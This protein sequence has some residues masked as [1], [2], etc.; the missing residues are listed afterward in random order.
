MSAELQARRLEYGRALA[1]FLE[2]PEREEARL[3]AYDFGRRALANGVGLLELAELHH[4]VVASLLA[5]SVGS[6]MVG[7]GGVV[8]G[9]GLGVLGVLL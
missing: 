1:E 7:V 9:G 6:L 8:I 4:E 3:S 5:L 2:N